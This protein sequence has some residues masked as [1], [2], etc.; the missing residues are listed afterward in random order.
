MRSLRR[1]L[2]SPMMVTVGL[3]LSA[4]AQAYTIDGDLSDWGVTPF[5]DWTPDPTASW[6]TRDGTGRGGEGYDLEALYV[7]DDADALYVAIVSSFPETGRPFRGETIVAGDLAIDVDLA[8]GVDWE[9]GVVGAGPDQGQV[10][11]LP[12]WSLLHAHLGYPDGAPS[13]LSG[14]TLV[15]QADFIYHNAGD[16]ENNGTDT[17]IIE[18]AIPRQAL[19]G[20][21]EGQTLGFH[22]AMSCGND[23]LEMQ[24]SVEVPE[25]ATLVV[26]AG[27]SMG[28]W[29]VRR[30]A[31]R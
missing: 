7:D 15:G 18:M 19:G 6:M 31:W 26:L 20:L 12:T 27:G 5:T 3:V 24:H 11:Y 1:T 4:T 29:A 23:V 14:G 30:R 13:N 8:N 10:Y 17:Y 28:L 16:L 9:Y 21:A 22:Y 25:P 2:G